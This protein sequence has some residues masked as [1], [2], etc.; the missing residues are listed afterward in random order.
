MKYTVDEM[1]AFRSLAMVE[2]ELTNGRGN[3]DRLEPFMPLV[4]ESLRPFAG[5]S[6]TDEQIAA[7]VQNDHGVVLPLSVLSTLL[8]RLSRR[9]YLVRTNGCYRF[10]DRNIPFY[11]TA[12]ERDTLSK[13]QRDLINKLIDCAKTQGIEYSQ[14]EMAHEFYGYLCSNFRRMEYLPSMNE[15]DIPQNQRWVHR[16][17]LNAQT[18]DV[19]TFNTILAL[20]KGLAVYDY[21]FYS[22]FKGANPSLRRLVA[23]ID[24]PI[25]CHALCMGTP[26]E[27][28][29]ARETMRLL[30]E[31]GVSCQVLETTVSEIR[32]ILRSLQ[33]DW[34]G[35]IAQRGRH[36]YAY[37]M[38][39]RGLGKEDVFELDG[40]LESRLSQL[41]NLRVVP[42]L[43][44][45]PRYTLD[46]KKLEERLADTEDVGVTS[47]VRHDVTA[48]ATVLTGRKGMSVRTIEDSVCV[49]V[50]S[51]GHTIRSVSLWWRQDE[52][53]E[54]LPPIIHI[55]DLANYAWLSSGKPSEID[56]FQKHNLVA[57]CAASLTPSEKV[58]RAFENKLEG[59]IQNGTMS[60][61]D[62]TALICSSNL[63]TCLS[64]YETDNERKALESYDFDEVVNR[65]KKE[66][67]EQYFAN[68]RQELNRQKEAL[69]QS[70]NRL[71]G[72][73]L[74]AEEQ[75]NDANKRAASAE[76]RLA[77]ASQ[78][79]KARN[80]KLQKV[81]S[82]TFKVLLIICI[83]GLF[84]LLSPW[85]PQFLELG[86]KPTIWEV[87]GS[88][89]SLIMLIA[90]A[91]K[92][93]DRLAKHCAM[94]LDS[95]LSV[96][97]SED[98]FDDENPAQPA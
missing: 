52:S 6:F 18:E 2:A 41:L 43:K 11:S 35:S 23:Y 27:E 8:R 7:A 87:L 31:S 95:L 76:K 63:H 77:V 53:Q 65:T 45:D 13:K 20:V 92:A 68:D 46:E 50:T 14:A 39:Q 9:K 5:T 38:H 40:L 88:S 30:Q 51:S 16:F 97:N 85:L 78:R 28:R 33:N 90:F 58:W 44:R 91:M 73:L 70:V 57:T 54:G 26:E 19:Q 72:D 55:T 86:E 61:E 59:W 96:S 3:Q 82:G 71:S 42:S 21:L 37:K 4:F 36:S 22:E 10:G 48:I 75:R 69:A 81:L 94:K 29:Y 83:G 25:L 47:R 66:L 74:L 1:K 62:A 93:P 79:E 60:Q 24:S 15:V 32:G 64:N 56:S 89:P 67:A 12:Q 17:I 34:E 84:F 98:L 80:T 49:F